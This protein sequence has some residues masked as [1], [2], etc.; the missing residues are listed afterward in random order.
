MIIIFLSFTNRLKVLLL[1]KIYVTLKNPKNICNIEKKI[2]F[3]SVVKGE[4]KTE[5][6]TQKMHFI[7][8]I[9][10]SRCI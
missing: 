8:Q 1:L 4:M 10:Q 2:S 7:E 5:V 9:F 6:I 3:C